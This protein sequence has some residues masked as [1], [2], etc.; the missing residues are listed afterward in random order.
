MAPFGSELRELLSSQFSTE[1]SPETGYAAF[2]SYSHTADLAFAPALH[3]ALHR[4]AKPMFK[5]RALH[6]FRDKSDLSV[7]PALWPVIQSALDRSK[8]FLLLASPGSAQSVWV[9]REIDYWIDL[10]GGSIDNLLIVWT[11]GELVW[12]SHAADFD[13]KRTTAIPEVLDWAEN[14]T[15][16]KS[17][18]G[19]FKEEP[20]YIDQRWAKT[21]TDLSL[22]NPKFLD[23]VATLA[24]TLHGKPKSEMIGEDVRQNRVLRNTRTTALVLLTLLLGA[25]SLATVYA[26]MQRRE[27]ERERE[28]AVSRQLS[29]QSLTRIDDRPDLALL[30]GIEANHTRPTID[31]QSILLTGLEHNPYLEAFL[32]GHTAEVHKLAFSPDGR[33]LASAGGRQDQDNTVRLWDVAS[34]RPL[35]EPLVG[36]KGPVFTVAFSPNGKLLA[37]AGEDHEI[38]L[39]NVAT[40]QQT[41]SSFSGHLEAVHALSFSPDGRTLASGSFGGRDI[42]GTPNKGEVRLWDVETHGQIGTPLIG[43]TSAVYSLAFSPDGRTLAS[44]SG[45]PIYFRSR[46]DYGIVIWDIATRSPRL[47][48]LGHTGSVLSLAF[49]P[50]GKVLASG[51]ADSTFRF[52]DVVTD[53]EIFSSKSSEP[54]NAVMEVSFSPDGKLFTL[55]DAQGKV[56][57]DQVAFTEGTEQ[58]ELSWENHREFEGMRTAAHM[59]FSPD[60]LHWGASRCSQLLPNG[61][62][63]LGEITLWNMLVPSVISE[64]LDVG[65]VYVSAVAFNP[66]GKMFATGGCTG[67]F[68][69]DCKGGEIRLWDAANQHPLGEPL[70][71]LHQE[72]GSLAFSPDGQTI[73]AGS[74]GKFKTVGSFIE[75]HEGEVL[76]WD[77]VTH[78]PLGETQPAHVGVVEELAVSRDGNLIAS[79]DR[80]TVILWDMNARR[81]LGALSGTSALPVYSM[82]ISADG[83]TLATGT[84][85]KTGKRTGAYEW[86]NGCIQ[87]GI[88][89]WDTRTR[90]PIGQPLVGHA[91]AVNSLAFSPNGKSL[92]SG[93]GNFDGKIILW[94]LTSR[95]QLG[96]AFVGHVTGIK[97]LIFS[98]DGQMLASASDGSDA[99][100]YDIILWNVE[101]RQPIGQPLAGHTSYISDIAFA[102]DGKRLISGGVDKQVM[103]W[104][105]GLDAW[106]AGACRVA[107]RNMTVAEWERYIGE[108]T[109]RRTCPGDY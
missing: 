93:S 4:F 98:S 52:W 42:E 78:R 45:G 46:D 101:T 41:G 84:C 44:G 37:S 26:E 1:Q 77:T 58:L 54:A 15:S 17:L 21:A 76:F 87:G 99:K 24:A 97:K 95:R 25:T 74:C 73:V 48:L 6:V 47:P 80:R 67:L 14:V 53:K 86:G 96:R 64:P 57:V 30:L 20:F 105:V 9:K 35:G 3:S 103:V 16:P 38:I 22:R 91:D 65:S 18:R 43:H 82:A 56:S 55:G 60:G 19:K 72:V 107:N 8:Y 62:C 83:T 27:A 40:G 2:I 7:T 69:A 63:S 92:V 102:P 5:L 39:W 31:S 34:H 88:Q 32:H 89:L 81:Q 10:H 33:L 100:H 75:C 109:H 36:H 71:G 90:Q 68:S 51:S 61:L 94:D 49:K 59:A 85:S 106:I 28:V 66:D 70:I 29:A 108:S 50:G 104:R 79:S 23:D 12:D 13:W 11:D